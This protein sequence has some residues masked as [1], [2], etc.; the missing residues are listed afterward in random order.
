MPELNDI[1]RLAIMALP[2]L[3]AIT[4]HEVAHGWAALRFGDT[5]AWQQGR[6]TLNP[7]A[8]IDPIGTII[9]PLVL[10]F[11]A[12][13]IFGWAKPVPVSMHRLPNPRRDMAFVALAGPLANFVMATGWA[14]VMALGAWL[15][16]V[17]PE[18]GQPLFFM[19]SAG[20]GVNVVLAVLNLVPLPPL[21][22]S[23]VLA[24]VLPA[25]VGVQLY[26]F[27]QAGLILLVV[28]MATG[29]LGR[30][31]GPVVEAVQQF[32]LWIVVSLLG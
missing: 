4:L 2:I 23:R 26:R 10:Y 13:F 6:L 1:Q 9:V 17:L 14:L 24:A 19:G 18:L 22:G 15:S 5:T 20:I 27:E 25:R 29:V 31:I 11:T 3:F 7:L 30:V 21:D 28:L 8:H 16:H 12:G 32:Y